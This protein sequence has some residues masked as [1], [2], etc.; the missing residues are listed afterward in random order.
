MMFDTVPGLT[1]GQRLESRL[2][3]QKPILSRVG[4]KSWCEGGQSSIHESEGLV[5]ENVASSAGGEAAPRT[6][7]RISDGVEAGDVQYVD[8]LN[9]LGLSSCSR[10]LSSPGESK[11]RQVPVRPVAA[12]QQFSVESPS[13][14]PP[15][16]EA[17]LGKSFEKLGAERSGRDLPNAPVFQ[18]NIKNSLI[19]HTYRLLAIVEFR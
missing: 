10:S 14:S 18:G 7:V 15:S 2:A 17:A 11:K 16:Y 9:K 12:R 5:G 4:R 6:T 13:V 3:P 8:E 19:V 1:L